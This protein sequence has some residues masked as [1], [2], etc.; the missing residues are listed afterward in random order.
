M[1]E[2]AEVGHAIDK[3]T[4]AKAVPELRESLLEALDVTSLVP[5]ADGGR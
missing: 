4:Y 3:K 5:G 2:S 1:F